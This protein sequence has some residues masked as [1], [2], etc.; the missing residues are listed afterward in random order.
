MSLINFK[1]L[2]RKRMLT[3]IV[4]LTLTSALFSITAYSFLGFYN[5]FT[6]YVGEE[7]DIVAI[8]SKIGSTPFTGLVQIG[9]ANKITTIEGVIVISPETI[10]PSTINGQSVFIRGIIPQELTKLNPLTI[11]EGQTLNI[12]DTSSAIIG[13]SL[14]DRLHLKTGD[15]ILAFSVLSQRYVE[16]QIKG[17][18]QSESSLNDE[19]LVPLYVGQWLR[20]VSYNDAT[21]IRARINVTQ[22]S[23]N[24]IFQQIA[25]QTSPQSAA[26][27]SPTPKS[28]TQRELEALIPL[29][30]ANLNVGNIGIEQSQQFMQ[31]YLDRYGISKDTL[32]ILSI[33]VLVFASGT[34]TCAITLFIKQHS[35]DIDILRS[36]GVS[37]KKV[38][39]DLTL[40]VVTWALIATLMGTIISAIVITIFQKI[41]YLQVLSHTITFQLDPLII[42]ANFMLLSVLISVNIARTE[43]KQ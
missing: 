42:I 14:A 8:Y 1:Y 33:V 10:S 20:G 18:F 26:S 19:A 34:A 7:K 23:A 4:I 6:N 13:K 39:T 28:E 2:R 31:N 37:T 17:V 29:A 15:K 27:P 25:N 41:G 35:S 12:T 32:I 22:T 16:L 40:R 38:K 24:Q 11:V 43:L 5:G 9:I 21:L 3:L 30:Q 36:I